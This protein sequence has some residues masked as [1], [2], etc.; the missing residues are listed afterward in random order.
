MASL[1]NQQV[2]L[3]KKLINLHLLQQILKI[4]FFYTKEFFKS[5]ERVLVTYVQFL[6]V[7]LQFSES[8]SRVQGFMCPLFFKPPHKVEVT[9]G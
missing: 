2:K 5:S 8:Y 1:N 9:Q 7:K 6:M 4:T 3:N